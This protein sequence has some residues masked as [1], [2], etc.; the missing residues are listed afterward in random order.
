MF[1]EKLVI[2]LM[3]R[4]Y[5]KIQCVVGDT[6]TL[7]IELLE[8]G[9]PFNIEGFSVFIEQGLSNDKFNIQNT[10]MIKNRNKITCNLSDKFTN[11]A[12]NHFLDISIAKGDEKKTTFKIPFEVYEGAIKEDSVEHE[13]YISVLE[14]IKDT[15]IKVDEVKQS[16]ESDV[17]N[18]ERIKNELETNINTGTN[19]NSDL[20]KQI[21]SG[22]TLS[23]DLNSKI[24]TGN[25]L[26]T[27][28]DSSNNAASTI[29]TNLKDTIKKANTANDNLQDTLDK[30]ESGDL[31]TQAQLNEVKKK[32]N[33]I[34]TSGNAATFNDYKFSSS[35]ITKGGNTSATLGT[36]SEPFNDAFIGSSVN[37]EWGYTTLPNGLIMCWGSD[38]IESTAAGFTAKTAY[39]KTA[40]KNKA[41]SINLS[42]LCDFANKDAYDSLSVV[43]NDDPL[44]ETFIFR[45][46]AKKSSWSSC[47]V[48]WTAIGY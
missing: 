2:D 6:L 4:N 25:D 30:V 13:I 31:V 16:I 36:K 18:A 5:S 20:K 40:F 26:K 15:L 38:Y 7:D 9:K 14:E 21:T 22:N 8:N 1:N 37:E 47:R 42:L 41:L 48:Y 33:V 44:R 34:G 11:V 35:A 39:F 12:G 43:A 24:S 28:L 27:K 23:S 17:I 19:L 3:K 45:L 32:V 46:N 29:N 10:N